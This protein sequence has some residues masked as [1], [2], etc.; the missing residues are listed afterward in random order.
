MSFSIEWDKNSS[1][2]LYKLEKQIAKRILEK[3]D[4]VKENPFRYLEHY[5]GQGYKLRIGA[6]RMLI[7]VNKDSKILTIQVFD[8]RD[9]I[10]KKK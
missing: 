4:E 8:K 2:F 10:Y 1:K 3:L 5:E 6:Y 7:D 9:R